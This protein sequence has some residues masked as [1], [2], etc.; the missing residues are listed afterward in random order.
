MKFKSTSIPPRKSECEALIDH[1]GLTMD[2][3]SNVVRKL[4]MKYRKL[5]R[6]ILN[7][8]HVQDHSDLLEIGPGPG[9]LGIWME[10]ENPTL[11]ITGLELSGDMIRVANEN[12]IAEH[13]QD[14]VHH[15]KGNA[16][17]MDSLADASFDVIFSNGS[18]HH[19]V[20]PENVFNEISRVLKPKGVFCITDGKRNLHFKA[21]LKFHVLK[22]TVPKS[23]S[24]GWKNSI[25]ASYTKEE[26][27]A[28]LDTT[29][30][31]GR[32]EVKA[33]MLNLIIHNLKM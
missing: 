31:K 22:F 33:D 10:Q 6:F 29:D 14:R 11:K 20:H 25:M 2:D 27:A 13:V 8:L 5:I 9:W 23:L 1:E 16:E 17:R 21:R 24:M 30:L 26:I 28:I 3:Y 4:E 18:L 15:V 32:Y 7:D 12:T 19:W